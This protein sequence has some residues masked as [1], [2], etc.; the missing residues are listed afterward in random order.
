MKGMRHAFL[1]VHRSADYQRSA[2]ESKYCR[3]LGIGLLHARG[4]LYHVQ[5][6]MGNKRSAGC[7]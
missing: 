2:A 4:A 3:G 7:R 5:A 1:Q 6:W